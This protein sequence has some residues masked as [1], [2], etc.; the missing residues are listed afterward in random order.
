M[1]DAVER[2]QDVPAVHAENLGEVLNAGFKALHEFSEQD[3]GV[4]LPSLEEILAVNAGR[5]KTVLETTTTLF[6]GLL[7]IIRLR[8]TDLHV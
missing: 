4:E 2:L 6:R 3:P 5:V 8:P 1:I 7:R